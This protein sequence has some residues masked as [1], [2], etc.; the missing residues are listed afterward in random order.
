[1]YRLARRYGADHCFHVTGSNVAFSSRIGVSRGRCIAGGN[2]RDWQGRA[3]CVRARAC[4]CY[5]GYEGT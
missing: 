1:M 2:A 3:I 5:S 4:V